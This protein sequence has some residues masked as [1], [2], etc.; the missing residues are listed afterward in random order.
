MDKK[1]TNKQ[2]KNNQSQKFIR[3]IDIYEQEYT[4]IKNSKFL[5]RKTKKQILKHTKQ[6]I[7]ETKKIDY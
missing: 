5:D 1:I 2:D 7:K 4:E 3:P 6:L